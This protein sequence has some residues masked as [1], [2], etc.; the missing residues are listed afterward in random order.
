MD[1][2]ARVLN[3]HED[4]CLEEL[5]DGEVV[6]MAPSPSTNHADVSGNIFSIFSTYLKGKKCKVYSAPVDV[7]LSEKNILIPDILVVCDRDKMKPRGC[8]GAPDLVVEIISPRTEQN[9]RGKK[10]IA[11]R[12]AG[13]RE[14]WIVNPY[15]RSVEVYHLQDNSDLVE[16][17]FDS[18][19][20]ERDE[21]TPA[22]FACGIF[23][24]L[25]VRLEDVFYDLW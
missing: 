4:Y 22:E 20:E 3:E 25:T 14:Y 12:E 1:N 23:P 2:T 10:K 5:I 6:M 13:V 17:Y 18:S 15:L 9:D 11:Y 7:Y 21:D 19:V 24:D 16:I 8:F